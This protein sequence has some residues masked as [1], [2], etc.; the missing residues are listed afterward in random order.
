MAVLPQV[1]DFLLSIQTNNYSPETIYNYER[2]LKVLENF[3]QKEASIPFSGLTKKH[4][5]Q[6]KAYLVSRD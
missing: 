4:I 1:D 6:Y 5:E 2:D 3:M